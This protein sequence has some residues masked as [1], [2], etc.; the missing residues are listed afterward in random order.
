[1]LFAPKFDTYRRELSS[2]TTARTGCAPIS[3][4][5]NTSLGVVSIIEMLSAP[6]L[7]VISSPPSGL[8]ARLTGDLPTSSRVSSLSRFKSMLATCPGVEHE[9]KAFDESGRIA[10]SSGF[11]HTL[12]VERTARC[13]VSISETVL[14]ARL[15]TTTVDP[16]GETR[17]RPG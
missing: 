3:K 12:M 5:L 14:S 11:M 2:D 16:S 1:M 8:R 15:V 6:K 7:H 4:L 10:M 9:I 13:A 17:A